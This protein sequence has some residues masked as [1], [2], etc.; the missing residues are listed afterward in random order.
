MVKPNPYFFLASYFDTFHP[1][2]PPQADFKVYILIK[3]E[4]KL[5]V[6]NFS[7]LIAMYNAFVFVESNCCILVIIHN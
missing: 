4:I 5:T 2:P 1:P 6:I 7:F 3:I